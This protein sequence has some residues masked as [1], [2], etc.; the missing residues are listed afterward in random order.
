MNLHERVAKTRKEKGITQ[1][2]LADMSNVTVRTIQRIE[3]GESIPR[4]YTLKALAKALDQS[5]EW[6]AADE[7][8]VIPAEAQSSDTS[9]FLKVFNL[10]CFAYI[11]VP[12][13]HFL[14][15]AII[16]HRQKKNLPENVISFGRRI[17]RRQI[18]WVVSLNLLMFFTLALNFIQGVA[19][20][21]VAY[22]VN[23]LWII[24]SMYLANGGIILYQA[25]IIQK[26][27]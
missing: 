13:I 3:S 26:K 16:L 19:F 23:Y 18:Y 9:H 10:S 1:E 8:V 22:L 14:I 17:I 2:E 11:V 27:F 12:W 20:N 15:P 24:F 4:S 7:T 6:L 21:N 25:M 5:Y